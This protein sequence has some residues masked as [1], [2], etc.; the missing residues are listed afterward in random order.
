[1]K[2]TEEETLAIID[3]ILK[4]CARGEYGE[5]K[6]FENIERLVVVTRLYLDAQQA[7]AEKETMHRKL[8]Q[9]ILDVKDE[10]LGLKEEVNKVYIEFTRAI[11]D[12]V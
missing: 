5:R 7:V 10:V 3:G 6:A 12:L 11:Q 1:M 8:Q 4:K 2:Y 9:E